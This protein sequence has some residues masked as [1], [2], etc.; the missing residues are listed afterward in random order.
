MKHFVLSD[1]TVTVTG[2]DDV[3][4]IVKD[5]INLLFA[6]HDVW[7]FVPANRLTRVAELLRRH[8]DFADMFV[9]DEVTVYR[10]S[11]TGEV[12]AFKPN[13]PHDTAT[14]RFHRLKL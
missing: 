5:S 10:C 8:G 6:L 14:A 7:Q 4:E 3:A 1:S 12:T 9:W 11:E 2:S 13:G